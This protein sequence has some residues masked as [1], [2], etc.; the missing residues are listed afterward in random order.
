MQESHSTLWTAL[1][2]AA[3]YG[4]CQV[5]NLLLRALSSTPHA[6]SSQRISVPQ[7]SQNDDTNAV[8]LLESNSE[9]P[10]RQQDATCAWKRVRTTKKIQEGQRSL[11]HLNVHHD[12]G[13]QCDS[14]RRHHN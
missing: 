4:Y 3:W 10:K 8:D 7:G 11:G 2:R 14:C 1:H 5:V 13:N 6:T 9:V 12:E